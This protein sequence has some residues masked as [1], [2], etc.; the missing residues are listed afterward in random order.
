MIKPKLE[1][2]VLLGKLVPSMED[3]RVVLSDFEIK[4]IIHKARRIPNRHEGLL[5]EGLACM[6]DGR[7]EEG[8]EFCERSISLDTSDHVAWLNY[9]LTLA[10]RGYHAKQREVLE[11]AL[12]YRLSEVYLS[13]LMTSV[14]W[15]DEQMFEQCIGV[16]DKTG[17]ITSALDDAQIQQVDFMRQLKPNMHIVSPFAQLAFEIADAERLITATSH[18]SGDEEH[19]Y[20]YSLGVQHADTDRLIELNDMIIDKII[21]KNLH[22]IDCVT[23]FISEDL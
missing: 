8:S 23:I 12:T 16:L 21:D 11:R 19:G 7:I 5:V 22:H 6:V 1:T 17:L 14:F 3:G 20:F 2:D 9:S 4:S 13:A 10:S 18:V 15:L